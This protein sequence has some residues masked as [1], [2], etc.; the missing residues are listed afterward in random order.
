MKSALKIPVGLALCSGALCQPQVEEPVPAFVTGLIEQFGQQEIANPP[1]TIWRYLYHGQSVYL[2][3]PGCC[4][5]FEDLYDADGNRI[6][7]PAGGLTGQG[8]GQCP[9]FFDVSTDET[10]I[11]RDPRA[12]S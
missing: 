7:A 3:V 5:Q 6:C 12:G 1:V 4:D 8:D 2:V 9:D 10:L 11:W